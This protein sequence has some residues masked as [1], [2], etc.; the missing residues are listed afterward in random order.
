MLAVKNK[1]IEALGVLNEVWD[2]IGLQEEQKE[3]RQD[4]VFMYIRLVS[5][6]ISG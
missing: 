1:L 4:L 6:C 3:S 5:L 2:D